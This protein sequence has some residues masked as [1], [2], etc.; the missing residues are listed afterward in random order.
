MAHAVVRTDNLTG[1]TDGAK[2]A[3]AKYFV[4]TTATEI[5]NGNIVK[6][7]SYILTDPER[8]TWKAV[9]PSAND[10]VES[11]NGKLGLV[12]TPEI[13]YDKKYFGLDTFYNKANAPVRVYLLEPGDEFSVTR[14]AFAAD[15]Y[16]TPTAESSP[17]TYVKL[18]AS[19]KMTAQATQ[20]DDGETS[21]SAIAYFADCIKEE[22]VGG[23]T[24][25]V[26]RVL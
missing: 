22:V 8:E 10:T 2:L 1:I 6:L 26:L 3:T 5:D 12:A 17:K 14:E 24:Y 9:A 21:P 20:P 15:A 13:I 18:T 7:D 19:T 23:I 25:Y 11:C 16:P 4:S